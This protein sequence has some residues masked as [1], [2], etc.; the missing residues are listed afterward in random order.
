MDEG[1][2]RPQFESLALEHAMTWKYRGQVKPHNAM[3]QATLDI[4]ETGRDARSS[5]ALATAS[6]GGWEADLRSI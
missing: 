2:A 4:T 6:L 5:T 3:M 1:F